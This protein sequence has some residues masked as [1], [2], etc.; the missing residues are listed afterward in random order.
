MIAKPLKLSI[1]LREKKYRELCEIVSRYAELS[2]KY[3][4]QSEHPIVNLAVC[5]YLTSNTENTSDIIN[6]THFD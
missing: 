6:L 4:I 2:E 3:F 5:S 1:D